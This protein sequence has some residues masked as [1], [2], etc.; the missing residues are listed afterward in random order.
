[1]SNPIEAVL[2]SHLQAAA[3]GV[4]AV[5]N[6][7]TEASILVTHDATFRGLAEIRGFFTD[8]LEG[9]TRGFLAAIKLTRQEVVGD[10]AYIAWEAMPWFRF[11]TDTFF[12]R[13]GKIL[14][15]TFGG[16]SART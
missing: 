16:L 5:M 8:L 3:A 7:Y 9:S 13:N 11:G 1:M 10:M 15:Q 4:D 6:D 12:I 2:E 14:V